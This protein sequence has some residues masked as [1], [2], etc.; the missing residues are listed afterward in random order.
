MNRRIRTFYSILFGKPP[1]DPLVASK[2]L[3]LGEALSELLHYLWRNGLLT[4]I[5]TGFSDLAKP[6][7]AS[8][9]FT[10]PRPIGNR[11]AVNTKVANRRAPAFGL[12]GLQKE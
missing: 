6:F 4:R 5:R 7:E 8:F 10:E 11:V 3:W 12:L 1:L 9:F 2:S